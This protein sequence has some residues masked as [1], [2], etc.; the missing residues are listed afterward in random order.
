VTIVV[1]KAQAKN[2]VPAVIG[3]TANGATS[4]LTTA[5]FRVVRQTQDTTNQAQNGIVL[6]QTPKGGTKTQKNT[7]VTIVV[8]KYKPTNTTTSTTTSTPTT[9]TTT[10]TTTS[11]TTPGAPK[12]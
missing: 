2:T 5:G 8:G 9:S 12:S 3:D 7:T 6:D 11:S 1:A 4:T 10:S